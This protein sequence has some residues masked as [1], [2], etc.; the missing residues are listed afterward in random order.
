MQRIVVVNEMNKI[1]QMDRHIVL[2]VYTDDDFS[3]QLNWNTNK[4][5]IL[6]LFD[7]IWCRRCLFLNYNVIFVPFSWFNIFAFLKLCSKMV[8]HDALNKQCQDLYQNIL[9]AIEGD[10]NLQPFSQKF[11][12]IL[13]R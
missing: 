4:N 7:I 1:F 12:A 13:T 10:E 8:D 9:V 3:K 11:S 6:F 2:W 5:S